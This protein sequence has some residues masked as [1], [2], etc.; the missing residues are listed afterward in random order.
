MTPTGILLYLLPGLSLAWLGERLR[1]GLANDRL[2]ARVGVRLVQISALGFAMR[3]LFAPASASAASQA[4]RLHALGWSL[5]WIAFLAGGL[6]LGLAARRGKVFSASCVA[7]A[8]F[9]PA[10]ALAGPAWLGPDAAN[11]LA[12]AA[13]AAWWLFALRLRPGAV[14]GDGALR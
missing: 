14:A 3:G 13:W 11:W 1:T 4:T 5:W 9:V 12:N 6:L 10:A 2:L 8:L 7:A